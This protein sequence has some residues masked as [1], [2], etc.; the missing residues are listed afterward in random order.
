MTDNSF[1]H[2]KLIPFDRYLVRPKM[3]GGESL[4]GFVYRFYNAN[5]VKAP[6]EI[7][8]LINNLS[9]TEMATRSTKEE[10]QYLIGTYSNLSQFDFF[11]QYLLLKKRNDLRSNY[12]AQHRFC[13]TC[14]NE[15]SNHYALWDLPM[16]TA[17]PIHGC[18]LVYFCEQCKLPFYWSTLNVDWQCQCKFNLKEST[19]QPASE[20]EI[21]ISKVILNAIDIPKASLYL[22]YM[23]EKNSNKYTLSQWFDTLKWASKFREILKLLGN[24]KLAKLTQHSISLGELD[25]TDFKFLLK[26]PSLKHIRKL[27]KRLSNENKQFVCHIRGFNNFNVICTE[28]ICL[29]EHDNPFTRHL[30]PIFQIVIKEYLN[31]LERELTVYLNTPNL[32]ISKPFTL[33]QFFEWWKKVMHLT[34]KFKIA[35]KNNETKIL[36]F[37]GFI[38]EAREAIFINLIRDSQL[39]GSVLIYANIFREWGFPES[40]KNPNGSENILNTLDNY[41]KKLDVYE[42][43]VL[44]Y[45][46]EL[47]DQSI[48]ENSVV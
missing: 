18:R 38:D 27:L 35:P 24:H 17:C 36:N 20:S 16:F 12:L 26:S 14:V 10:L 40:L 45:L 23:D 19:S 1:N 29:T 47:A 44:N 13:P 43:L 4:R 48:K 42:L 28:C 21:Y 8:P 15:K 6:K 11:N 39:N 7:W 22:E 30:I 2:L 9:T 31:Q 34:A 5:G 32:T 25:S 33:H 37:R 3:L 41:L 46:V